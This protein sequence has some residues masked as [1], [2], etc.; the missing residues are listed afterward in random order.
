MRNVGRLQVMLF[1]S[2]LFTW[3]LR[4]NTLEM[5][6][7]VAYKAHAAERIANQ[8]MV[9]SCLIHEEKAHSRQQ[10]ARH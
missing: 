4:L 8:S 10:H 2:I 1:W 6:K 3:K 9:R 5:F 7:S